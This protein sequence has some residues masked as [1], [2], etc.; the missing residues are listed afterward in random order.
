MFSLKCSNAVGFRKSTFLIA[1]T[2]TEL[3]T[4]TCLSVIWIIEK[5]A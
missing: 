1:L 2:S 5:C 4:C 3:W